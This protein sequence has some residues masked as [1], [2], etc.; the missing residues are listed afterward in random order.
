M[1]KAGVALNRKIVFPLFSTINVWK[2]KEDE[3]K[4]LTVRIRHL[5]CRILQQ[6]QGTFADRRGLQF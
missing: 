6:P 4:T 2:T 3:N 5:H 1:Y